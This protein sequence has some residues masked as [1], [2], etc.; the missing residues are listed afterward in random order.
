MLARLSDPCLVIFRGMFIILQ[1][2]RTKLVWND[3]CFMAF[4]A[5]I[6][7]DLDKS[8][9]RK[10]FVYKKTYFDIKKESISK[11]RRIH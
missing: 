1:T 10:Y 3:F 6:F 2:Y 5:N 11:V 7:A 4:C 8:V 9:N